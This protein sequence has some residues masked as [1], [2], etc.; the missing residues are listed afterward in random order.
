MVAASSPAALVAVA[1]HRHR[2][3]TRPS[4]D[5]RRLAGVA[6]GRDVRAVP[7]RRRRCSP[8]A[9]RCDRRWSSPDPSRHRLPARPVPRPGSVGVG[10]GLDPAAR[11]AP[12]GQGPARGHQRDPRRTRRRDHHRHPARQHRRHPHRSAGARAGR[13]LRPATTRRRAP[14]WPALVARARVRGPAHRDDPRHRPRLR[15]RPV[16]RRRRVR[17]L[18]GRQDPH[19][20][21]SP[22]PRRS[23]R[24]SRSPR[25][26]FGWTLSPSAAADAVAILSSSPNAAPGW[27]DSL[28]SMIHS[29]PRTRDSIW[30][31]VSL[32]LSCLADPRVL[33]AVSPEPGRALRPRRLPHQQRH[34]LPARHR[35]RSRRVLVAG[36]S[37]HR[38]PRRNRPPSRRG[39]TRR[40]AR[41]AAAAGARR[42]RQPLATALAAGAHGRRRRHRASRR[43][44]CCSRCPRRATSGATTR[45]ARSGTPASSRSSSAAHPQPETSKTSP[46]SSASATNAPTPSPSATTAPGPSNARSGACRSCRQRPSAPC[47][48][49]PRSILLRSAPPLVTDL[50]PWTDRKEADQLRGNRVKGSG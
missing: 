14:G 36:R 3:S 42:D 2:S 9:E 26:L 12:L 1:T 48:S 47:H 38:R 44:R 5:P 40:T 29:D 32:A 25:E 6:T 23:P 11:P 43:C 37:L 35:R 46:P 18:L 20:P 8:A 21:P 49:A 45:P 13:R 31:G 7:P 16:D 50:R 28:E 10:R 22:A 34:P 15:H 4:H 30:M 33:D 27:A 24:P 17:R 39:V 41:P 19:R